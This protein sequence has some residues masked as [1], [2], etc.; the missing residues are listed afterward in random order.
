VTD[1]ERRNEKPQRDPSEG[2][3]LIGETEAAQAFERGDVSRRLSDDSPRFGDRPPTPSPPPGGARPALRFPLGSADD[4][5]TVE[6][7]APVPVQ[8]RAQ[9]PELSHWAGSAAEEVPNMSR[10]DPLENEG[11]GWSSFSGLGPRWRD[12]VPPAEPARGPANQW[13]PP[14]EPPGRGQ[15]GPGP[16]PGRGIPVGFEDERPDPLAGRSVFGDE[17]AAPATYDDGYTDDAYGDE[18]YDEYA[19]D[20]DDGY[21]PDEATAAAASRGGDWAPPDPDA[22]VAPGGS[23]PGRGRAAARR[24]RRSTDRDMRTAVGVGVGIVVVAL[25]LLNFLGPLG[26]MIL[27]VP[28]LGYAIYEFLE[29]AGK[30]GFEPLTYVGVAATVGMAITAYN[31][32]EGAMPLVLV[33]T[34]VVSFLWYLIGAGDQ[35]PAG[36]IG[37]TLLGVVWIGLFGSFAA[38]LLSVPTYG[39]AF[40]LA[41]VVPTVAYDIGGLFVGRSAGSRALSSASPNKTIEGLA[42]GMFLAVVAGA[43]YGAVGPAPFDSV[44]EGIALGLVAALA[45]PIGDLA[46]SLIKRDLDLKDMGSILPGHGGLLDRFDAILFVLPA[47][48]YLSR[49]SDFFLT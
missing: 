40:L 48:W 6:R 49:L 41:A 29:S 38:L 2:V 26:G 28:I 7:P 27:V 3:R 1:R 46:E 10:R 30:A 8:P 13:G 11:Q 33:L 25:L 4:P 16:A 35:Q 37:V 45:A 15:P 34:A 20:Y 42:G 23:V 31:Y 14:D 47:V 18:A 19:D 9:G 44:S 24:P 32:G 43:V 22:I 39:V 36:N 12:D 21:Y 5:A 17:P